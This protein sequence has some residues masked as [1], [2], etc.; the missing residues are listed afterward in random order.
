[1]SLEKAKGLV[2]DPVYFGMLMLKDEKAKRMVW[3][4][5]QFTRQQIH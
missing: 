4:Q 3:Y 5:E 2:K 1:M